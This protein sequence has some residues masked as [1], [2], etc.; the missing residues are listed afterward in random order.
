VPPIGGAEG[1]GLIERLGLNKFGNLSLNLCDGVGLAD[2]LAVGSGCVF[3]RG[4]LAVGD[5]TGDSAVIGEVAVS[6]GVAV[7]SALLGWR[8][9]FAGEGDCAGSWAGA[10]T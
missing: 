10:A 5:T 2:G 4:R 8:C 3:L 6:A 7:V 1:D 9:F